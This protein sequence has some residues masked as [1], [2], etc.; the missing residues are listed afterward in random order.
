MAY[1]DDREN[2]AST[3][4]SLVFFHTL[5]RRK[6]PAATIQGLFPIWEN[7]LLKV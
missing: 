4:S 7:R 3:P 2:M 6:D 1:P 5:W